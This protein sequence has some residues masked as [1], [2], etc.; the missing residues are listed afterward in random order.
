MKLSKNY[1]IILKTYNNWDD[2]YHPTWYQLNGNLN[3]ESNLKKAKMKTERKQL[4]VEH[5][6]KKEC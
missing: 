1:I 2:S 3:L 4:D 5:W 6:F